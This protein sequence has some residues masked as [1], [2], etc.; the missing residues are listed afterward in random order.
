MGI[1]L[2]T[3]RVNVDMSY[4]AFMSFRKSVA[5]AYSKRFGETYENYLKE[6]ERCF[7]RDDLEGMKRQDK[8]LEWFV[9]DNSIPEDLVQFLL[10]SDCEGKINCKT[11]RLVRDL[12]LKSKSK[13]TFGYVWNA[14]DMKKMAEV[15]DDGVKH[16][17]N[18]TWR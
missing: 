4:G 14:R 7:L 10:Q 6:C 5:F 15:F 8:L 13:E 18:V 1:T 9:D 11:A 17:V 3:K 2:G 16:R 12:C